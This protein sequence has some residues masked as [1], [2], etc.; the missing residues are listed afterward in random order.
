MADQELLDVVV[1]DLEDVVRVIGVE[2]RVGVRLSDT[3]I[4]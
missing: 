4:Y 3:G 2:V 1:L